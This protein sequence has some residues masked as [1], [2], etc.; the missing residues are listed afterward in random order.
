MNGTPDNAIAAGLR[1]LCQ[2]NDAAQKLFTNFASRSRDSR[3]TAVARAASLAGADYY[4]MLA[5]FKQLETL[6]VGRFI[7][8][9]HGYPSRI[10]WQFSIRS[11]GEVA[12]G[13]KAKPEVVAA[14]AISDDEAD[15]SVEPAAKVLRHEFQLRDGFR[16]RLELPTDINQREAERLAAF[17]KALP[18]D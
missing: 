14:D 18:F 5:I 4:A 8:G 13:E 2:D 17:I 16:V 15:E 3:E 10:E 9:R 12:R 6:G 7:P 1:Q 11:L